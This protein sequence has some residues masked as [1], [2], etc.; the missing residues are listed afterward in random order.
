MFPKLKKALLFSLLVGLLQA[1]AF[2]P[3]AY[4]LIEVI[5]IKDGKVKDIKFVPDGR[6]LPIRFVIIQVP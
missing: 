6:F 2:C 1:G 5:T 3:R 4:P